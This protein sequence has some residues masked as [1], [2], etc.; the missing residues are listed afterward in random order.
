MQHQHP[1]HVAAG[2]YHVGHTGPTI[3]QAFLGTCVGVAIY[4]SE[5]GVGG[6]IHLLL[7]EPQSQTDNF[8]PEK[9]ASTGIPVFLQA[10]YA[11]GASKERLKAFI[12]GGA[13]VG[14]IESRDLQL[15]IGGR[16]AEMAMKR[17]MEAEIRIGQSETGGLFTSRLTLAMQDWQCRIEPSGIEKNSEKYTLDLPTSAEIGRAME[18]LQPIPQVALKILRMIDANES[19]NKDLAAEIGKDQV[20]TARTLRLCNSVMFAGRKK[21]ESL[22]HALILLGLRLLVKLVISSLVDDF[23]SQTGK[24][25]SLCKGG[26]FHH[27]VGTAIIAEELAKVTGKANPGLAYTA[28]L[29]HDIG[30]VVLDQYIASAYPLFYRDLFEKENSFLES[31]QRILS[32]DHTQVGSE[33]AQ[34][35]SFPGTLIETIRHHHAPEQASQHHELV[36]LVYLADLLMSRFH[37]G[38][39]LER[40]DTETLSAR[41]ETIGFTLEQFPE[42]VDLIPVK[43][44]EASPEL[45]LMKRDG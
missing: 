31:E 29:L 3:L 15:D 6:I 8:A 39:E 13:L 1:Y 2:S 10:L 19:E 23:F 22:E 37:T 24:G 38:L 12:A 45:A 7:A 40:L 21:I 35:W 17:L 41:L 33:L 9:Y 30:K 5:S 14:P 32:I 16:T 26:L 11:E 20:I 27:A 42:I 36:H 28:G 18:K 34:Q 44:F 43:V 25:Y 4:D